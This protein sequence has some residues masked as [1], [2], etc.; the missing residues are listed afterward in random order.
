MFTTKDY[1]SF[2]SEL[3]AVELE[4]EKEAMDLHAVIKDGEARKL[5]IAVRDDERRH[6]DL[7]REMIAMVST[8]KA[9]K[10]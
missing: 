7:V 4:M 8:H 6:A 5:L 9:K 10:K 2:F 3:L 1:L